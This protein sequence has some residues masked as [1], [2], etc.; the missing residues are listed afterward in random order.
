MELE[1]QCSRDQLYF[2]FNKRDYLKIMD[3]WVHQKLT[4]SYLAC[5]DLTNR[6]YCLYQVYQTYSETLNKRY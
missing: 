2:S 6:Y 4:W 5:V 3:N 1:V